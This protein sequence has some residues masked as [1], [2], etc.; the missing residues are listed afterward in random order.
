MLPEQTRKPLL[1]FYVGLGS[2]HA[3]VS[4][5]CAHSVWCCFFAAESPS[6]RGLGVVAEQKR[7][8]ALLLVLVLC[9]AIGGEAPYSPEWPDPSK[10]PAAECGQ[11]MG[12][13]ILGENPDQNRPEQNTAG[14]AA[15]AHSVCWWLVATAEFCVLIG[16]LHKS[17]ILF[18]KLL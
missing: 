16:A 10:N 9:L 4:Q 12:S 7:A 17:A 15:R 5:Q 6:P 8:R 3:R 11:H 14:A 13:R 18:A 2:G 1:G